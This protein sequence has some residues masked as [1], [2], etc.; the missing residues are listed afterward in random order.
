MFQNLS[1]LL[2]LVRD[3]GS[4]RVLGADREYVSCKNHAPLY[5][6]VFQDRPETTDGTGGLAG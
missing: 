1:C 4:G 6:F 5:F 3:T 2:Q